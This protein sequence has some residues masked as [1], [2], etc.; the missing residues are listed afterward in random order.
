[1]ASVVG[2]ERLTTEP[3]ILAGVRRPIQ[4]FE[5]LLRW[6]TRSTRRRPRRRY[7]ADFTSAAAPIRRRIGAGQRISTRLGVVFPESLARRCEPRRLRAHGL[8]CCR[9]SMLLAF[10]LIALAFAQFAYREQYSYGAYRS[11]ASKSGCSAFS[12]RGCSR[13]NETGELLED[14]AE[15]PVESSPAEPDLRCV[16]LFCWV[17]FKVPALHASYRCKD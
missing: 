3:P 6:L 5:A 11:S 9:W 8:Q 1:M 2:A 10:A 13:H 12:R 7:L 17:R 15:V 4:R 16:W 14:E